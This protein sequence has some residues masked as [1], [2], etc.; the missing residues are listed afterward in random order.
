MQHF[1]GHPRRYSWVNQVDAYLS[2]ANPV[3]NT[4]YTVLAVTP[5]CNIIGIDAYV[6]WAVTQPTPI[7]V[8]MY[9]D[10]LSWAFS[11]TNPVTNT[12][13]FAVINLNGAITGQI[14][15]ATDRSPVRPYLI[16]GKTVYITVQVTWAVTQPTPLVCRVRYAKSM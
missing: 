9:I 5:Y 3:S 11:K 1:D 4:E 14:L 6:T 8:N 12:D 10:G 16:K 2:Q 15:D 13:Y 7:T